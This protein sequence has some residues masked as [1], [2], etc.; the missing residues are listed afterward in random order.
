[1]AA[2]L[3]AAALWTTR[4]GGASWQPLNIAL[5]GSAD[6]LPLASVE[7]TNIACAAG[8]VVWVDGEGLQLVLD[9]YLSAFT[10]NWELQGALWLSARLRLGRRRAR[11]RG[12]AAGRGS[13]LLDFCFLSLPFATVAP[14]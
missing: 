6:S 2:G 11:C 4:D 3:N 9:D 1:M 7:C 12:A 10:V 14:R 13:H 8:P 5:S